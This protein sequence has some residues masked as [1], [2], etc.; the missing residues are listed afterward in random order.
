MLGSNVAHFKWQNNQYRGHSLYAVSDQSD[1]VDSVPIS[2]YC[3]SGLTSAKRNP[4]CDLRP[5]WESNH[6]KCKWVGSAAQKWVY[7]DLMVTFTQCSEVFELLSVRE[8]KSKLVFLEF[9]SFVSFQW[10][11]MSLP[12]SHHLYF[13]VFI[14]ASLKNWVS[15]HERLKLISRVHSGFLVIVGVT[16]KSLSFSDLE[17]F[18]ITRKPEQ[19][20]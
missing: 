17:R 10:F 13:P 4:V 5:L 2:S 3:P 1:S 12:S 11:C 15:A 7:L 16:L 9:S 8:M 19:L 6:K 18:A 20:S 14:W